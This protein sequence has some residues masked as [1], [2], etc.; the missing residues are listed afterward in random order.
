VLALFVRFDAFRRAPMQAVAA[1]R[2]HGARAVPG[3]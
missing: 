2:E 1:A 3:L